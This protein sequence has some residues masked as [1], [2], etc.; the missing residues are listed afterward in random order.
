MKKTGYTLATLAC[1]ACSLN[2][3]AQTVSGQV[4]GYD[5]VDLGLSV[6]WATYNVG[7]TKPTETGNFFAWGE[8]EPKEKYSWE[9]Y[10]WCKGR[11]NTLTKYCL[12]SSAG[13]RDN[14]L[15]LEPEDDAAHV[16]LGGT[17][18]MP[19][20]DECA[21]LVSRC[22]W[23]WTKIGGVNGCKVTASN[24]N[25]IFLPAA[26]YRSG[27]VPNASAGSVGHYWTTRLQL[28]EPSG[29]Q[30]LTDSPVQL[31]FSSGGQDYGYS[32]SYTRIHGLTIR[33]VTE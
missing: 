30:P 6:K 31:Y 5:Y 4:A 29:V 22:T 25:S 7:A 12:S 24:G 21:R 32:S 16:I 27:S 2:G 11:V 15:V 1:L 10:K 19:A 23:T 13:T 26:G 33:P 17:W 3:T 20:W 18:R 8:T 9:N 14:K 28:P